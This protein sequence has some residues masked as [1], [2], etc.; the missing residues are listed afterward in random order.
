LALNELMSRNDSTVADGVGELD[1]WVELYNL[2]DADIAL[3][4]MT[5]ED[6]A[7]LPAP[8]PAGAV[9]PARGFLL[10]FTDDAPAQGSATEPHM[11]FKLAGEG[12]QLTLRDGDAI[13]DALAFPALDVDVSFGLLPDGDDEAAVLARAT[14]GVANDSEE[15]GEGEGECMPPFA[16]APTIVVNEVLIENATPFVDE[17]A[18][19]E[20]WIELFNTSSLEPVALAGL[21]LAQ[22]G[23]L[24]N[25]WPLPAQS[26]APL[27]FLVVFADGE[28]ADGPLHASFE[29][30]AADVAA[31]GVVLTD[32]CGSTPFFQT[33]PLAAAGPNVSVGLLPDGD[34]TNAP[35]ARASP[36]PGA[37]ND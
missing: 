21:V 25:A 14:P 10:V 2:T 6:A 11:P 3:G 35:A 33:M 26:L 5:L 22:D 20:P 16:A 23:T 8:F 27:A 30:T 29:L 34:L 1:D 28:P 32:V 12:D 31:G 24:D 17:Q 4:G 36:T 9:V 15:G 18:E 7:A 13:V 37:A 19:A